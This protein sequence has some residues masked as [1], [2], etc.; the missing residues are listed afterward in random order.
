[1]SCIVAGV[2][3]EPTLNGIMSPARHH[4]S[5]PRIRSVVPKNLTAT[6]HRVCSA[7]GNRTRVTRDE[8]PGAR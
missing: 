2:G 7:D 3:V 4:Y 8:S 1:M 5:L 6:G